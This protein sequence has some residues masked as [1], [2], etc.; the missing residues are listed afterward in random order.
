VARDEAAGQD[1]ENG[2]GG[3]ELGETVQ[4]SLQGQEGRDGLE[5]QEGKAGRFSLPAPPAFP[6]F[7]A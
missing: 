5:G 1:Q 4:H 6:A 2:A 3:E 7:P